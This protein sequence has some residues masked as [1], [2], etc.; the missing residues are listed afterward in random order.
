MFDDDFTPRSDGDVF[1]LVL[2]IIFSIV[3]AAVQFTTWAT[4]DDSSCP[5]GKHALVV[6]TVASV[7]ECICVDE[8]R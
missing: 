2:L 8:A 3:I 6:K 1:W 5:K 7:Y 4:C